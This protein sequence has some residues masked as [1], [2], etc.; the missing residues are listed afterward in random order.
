MASVTKTSTCTELT[1]GSSNTQHFSNNKK[2]VTTSG[3]G[4]RS[5]MMMATCQIKQDNRRERAVTSLCRMY[6][7]MSS[8]A[9]EYT[10]L[11]MTTQGMMGIKQITHHEPTKRKGR[12]TYSSSGSKNPPSYNDHPPS[13]VVDV[14]ENYDDDMCRIVTHDDYVTDEGTT[15]SGVH[16]MDSSPVHDVTSSSGIHTMNFSP[17]TRV[18]QVDDVFETREISR[19]KY[20]TEFLMNEENSDKTISPSKDPSFTTE[21]SRKPSSLSR[22]L[23][24]RSLSSKKSISPAK[25]SSSDTTSSKSTSPLKNEVLR[26]ET[27]RINELF[28][29]K[30]STTGDYFCFEIFH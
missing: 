26:S 17:L 10:A 20:G 25:N 8:L 28:R 3:V 13:Y 6:H 2:Q 21:L 23:S 18:N 7:S 12:K 1:K 27:R 22:K 30:T 4:N 19:Y 29:K 14:D 16:T 9:K 5:N 11:F 24:W 15:S